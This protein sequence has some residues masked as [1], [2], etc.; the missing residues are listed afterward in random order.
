[1]L[2]GTTR[3]QFIKKAAGIGAAAVGAQHPAIPY[4]LGASPNAALGVAVV[5]AG[6]MGGYSVGAAMS[7]RIVA[8]CDVDENN[9]AGA[10]KNI[11]ERQKDKP[12]PKVYHDYRK[13]LDECEKDLD[14]VLIAT[15]DHNHAPAAIRA[16]KLGKAAF[17]QKPLAHDV[18]ECY[19]LAKAAKAEK[20]LT[21]MGNQGHCGERIRRVCEYIWA[22]AVG[23]IT[24]TH[25]ILGR[26][27]GGSGG[28]PASKAV[29]KG[30]HWDEWLGPA[31]YRDYHDGLHPFSWRSW[32]QFGTGTIGDM[33]CHNIDAL[34]WALKIGKARR[35]TVECL[36]SKGGSKE[37]YPQD[38]IIRWEVPARAD[39]PAVKVYVY[40]H[41]G[42]KPE[43]MKETESKHNRRFGE[44]TLFVGDDGLIGTDARIIPEEKHKQTP[45]PPKSI[46]R[47]HG[48]PI[49]D[50]FHAMKND[51]TPCSN[52]IDSAG[53]LT[54]F[55]LTGHLAMFAGVGKKL[56]WD[57]EKMQCTN[58]PEINRYVG[59]E[60]RAGW[61][62]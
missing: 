54:A 33:A 42:L 19:E 11:G 38:N 6:G 28:R 30:L 23:N 20:V 13:M 45:A 9:I 44:F 14:V 21:Q 15:P 47:A 27:F 1:M 48:G 22:G 31:A 29:P 46:P 62:V 12:A 49:E 40:D 8:I 43:I 7:E 5:G 56:D 16:I 55:A 36:S 10:M 50:L 60:Y 34:F 58:M 18:R 25:T 41:E 57:V 53:P 39:M 17:S 2:K 59:R 24:A 32:R 51:G 61:E 52:F 37:M 26:N 3:R 35:F 4:V